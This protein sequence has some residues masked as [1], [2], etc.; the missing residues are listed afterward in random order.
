MGT[1]SLTHVYDAANKCI[2]TIYRQMDGYPSCHGL[3]LAKICNVTI[4]NGIGGVP[5]L[6][7]IA[8]GMGC[9]AAQIVASLKS[10]PGSIYIQSP[11][12]KDCGEEYVYTVKLDAI[13]NPPRISCDS[14]DFNG[15]RT[16]LKGG[17]NLIPEKF[18]DWCAKSAD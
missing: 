2:M 4:T 6:N 8:N 5:D 10:G 1:R 18:N 11:G 16:K 3:A 12:A 7:R 17:Q 15:K 9:L 13:G 14:A